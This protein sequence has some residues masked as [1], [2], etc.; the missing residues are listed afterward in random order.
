M[1]TGNGNVS[2]Q[3]RAIDKFQPLSNY[4]ENLIKWTDE[5][6][7]LSIEYEKERKGFGQDKAD[8][9]ILLAG[10]ILT[11]IETKKNCG[12]EMGYE[13]LLATST[14][15]VA[16]V[17]YRSMIVHENNYKALEK[18]IDAYNSKIMATQSI[19]KYNVEGERRFKN[20]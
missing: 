15:G 7:R 19:M 8:L 1:E 5:V 4:D 9:D 6:V 18:I 16:E 13:L 3:R 20:E 11:F 2:R 12:I 14:N 17:L 10:K